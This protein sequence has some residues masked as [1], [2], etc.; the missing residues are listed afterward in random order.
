MDTSDRPVLP[1]TLAACQQTA[2]QE[3]ERPPSE[4]DLQESSTARSSRDLEPGEP[5][6]QP[7]KVSR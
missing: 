6:P 7:T 1:E 5:T 3:A 4:P 2:T